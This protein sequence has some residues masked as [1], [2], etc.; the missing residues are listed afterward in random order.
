MRSFC[1]AA[2]VLSLLPTQGL[3]AQDTTAYRIASLSAFLFKQ[4][5]A[6]IDTTD[7][8]ALDND[9]PFN[10]IIGGGIARGSPSGATFVAVQLTGPYHVDET[11]HRSGPF[12]NDT[13]HSLQLTAQIDGRTVLERAVRLRSLFSE[14]RQVW[15][16]FVVYGTGCG[17]LKLTATLL[18]E[19]QPEA[20]LERSV[21]FRC[22]E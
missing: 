4:T 12:A 8:L 11:G 21:T 6:S 17:V 20:T 14:E 18:R 16:P 22:G 7:L 15:V 2:L 10:T 3:G 5:T 13:S 1:Y 19:R 9:E